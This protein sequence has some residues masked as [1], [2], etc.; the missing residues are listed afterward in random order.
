M[1]G[2]KHQRHQRRLYFFLRDFRLA[3]NLPFEAYLSGTAYDTGDASSY[4]KNLSVLE[5]HLGSLGRS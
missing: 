3:R 5:E 4:Q 1:V 2:G